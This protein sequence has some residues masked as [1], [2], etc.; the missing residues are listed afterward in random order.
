[1]QAK[2]FGK[3]HDRTIMIECGYLAKWYP[4][5]M[6]FVDEASKKYRVIVQAY[7]G[8]NDNEPDKIFHS[9]TEDSHSRYQPGIGEKFYMDFSFKW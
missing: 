4:G 1:M 6:P 2:E 9:I 8:F 7:D 3:E 5:L